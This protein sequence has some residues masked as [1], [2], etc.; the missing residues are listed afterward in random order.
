MG[1]YLEALGRNW[2][3]TQDIRESTVSGDKRSIQVRP[4][5]SESWFREEE[6]GRQTFRY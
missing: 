5:E 3:S 4:V 6:E 2:Q 1:S